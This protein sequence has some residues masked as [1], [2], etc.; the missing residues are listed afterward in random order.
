[1]TN[2][3]LIEHSRQFN[4]FAAAMIELE[5]MKAANHERISTGES[6]AYNEESFRKLMRDY[7]F[8]YNE[9][10]DKQRNYY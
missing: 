4:D 8:G 9:N 1:M 10:I 7:S 5:A 6:L 2:S 3:I